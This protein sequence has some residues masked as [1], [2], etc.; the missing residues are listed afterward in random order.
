MVAGPSVG[1]EI[2]PDT[3]VPARVRRS[4]EPAVLKPLVNGD[5]LPALMVILHRIP[6]CRS[7]L[8][9][10]EHFSNDYGYNSHWWAGEG[11]QSSAISYRVD[12]P[13]PG[14]PV[15]ASIPPLILETQR[16]MAFL[17]AT[18]RSYGSAEPLSRVHAITVQAMTSLDSSSVLQ[19]FLEAWDTMRPGQ[20]LFRMTVTDPDHEGE[21]NDFRLFHITNSNIPQSPSVLTFSDVLDQTLWNKRPDGQ[22]DIEHFLT[23]L[24]S[25]MVVELNQ[26]T[27]QV[28]EVPTTLNLGR[29][30]LSSKAMIDEV[31]KQN[32]VSIAEMD[33]I[34]SLLQKIQ[35]Y[36]MPGL[37]DSPEKPRDATTM[38]EN[39]IAYLKERCETHESRF[40]DVKDGN[41]IRQLET[42]LASMKKRIDGQ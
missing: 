30:L 16:L 39:S 27:G 24:P 22:F 26:H 5:F 33:R 40:V 20:Q 11:I 15:A 17:D 31:K 41:A 1:K 29:Y 23:R 13:E 10:P 6:R 18:D 38:L 9:A 21:N 12:R 28:I 3:D 36:K 42:T 2:V 4:G 35:A 25:I 37:Q 32:A 8:L 14:S 7:E 19:R 34:D